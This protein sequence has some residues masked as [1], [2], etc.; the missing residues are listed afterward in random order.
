MHGKGEHIPSYV[1]SEPPVTC[2]E[3]DGEDSCPVVCLQE[4]SGLAMSVYS[5]KSVDNNDN[6]DNQ[7]IPSLYPD[8]Q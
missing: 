2:C 7:L 4:T 8:D 5:R 1:H 6:T 3:T